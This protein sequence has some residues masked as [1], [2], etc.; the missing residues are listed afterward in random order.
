[1]VVLLHQCVSTNSHVRT[2]GAKPFAACLVNPHHL[3]LLL[4]SLVPVL[5]SMCTQHRWCAGNCLCYA[6]SLRRLLSS[7]VHS[8]APLQCA[9]CRWKAGSCRCCARCPATEPS[10]PGPSHPP[11]HWAAARSSRARPWLLGVDHSPRGKSSLT[12]Q[13]LMR[14]ARGVVRL[15]S[16]TLLEST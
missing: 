1:M 10:S 2:A 12:A 7:P 3:R 11:K 14:W 4:S 16:R 6:V 13:R 9:H 15:R 8:S 5:A